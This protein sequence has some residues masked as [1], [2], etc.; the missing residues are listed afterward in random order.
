MASTKHTMV[1]RRCEGG[2]MSWEWWPGG[3]GIAGTRFASE[4]GFVMVRRRRG[5]QEASFLMW[6]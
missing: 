3:A 2:L 5:L 1:G 4:D 6:M